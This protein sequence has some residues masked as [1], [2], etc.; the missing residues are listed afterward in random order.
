MSQS[1][2]VEPPRCRRRVEG[3]GEV[4]GIMLDG[5]FIPALTFQEGIE[6]ARESIGNHSDKFAR[7]VE[8]AQMALDSA[9]TQAREAKELEDYLRF[10]AEE[11]KRGKL[12]YWGPAP[13]TRRSRPPTP[14]PPPTR[15]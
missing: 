12:A 7:A 3:L 14:P 10:L 9:L 13:A 2:E 5:K 8:D 1:D 4:D 15:R 11:F 6:E